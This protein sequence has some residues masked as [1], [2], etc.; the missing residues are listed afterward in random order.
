MDDTAIEAVVRRLA[1][2]HPS[3]GR[4]IE[5]AAIL[6]EGADSSELLIWISDHDGQP[7]AQAVAASEGRG[8]HSDR[9][10]SRAAAAGRPPLRYVLPA[11]ALS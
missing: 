5:R 8:L 11:D 3:G 9:A 7:E 2:P 1:R 4:V 10:D 6:A